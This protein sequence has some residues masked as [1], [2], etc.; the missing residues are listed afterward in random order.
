M[1]W[2]MWLRGRKRMERRIRMRCIARSTMRAIEAVICSRVWRTIV[3]HPGCRKTITSR[4]MVWINSIS[5]MDIILIVR[6]LRAIYI[7]AILVYTHHLLRISLEETGSVPL[8]KN[9]RKIC[10]MKRRPQRKSQRNW[11]AI[12]R[13]QTTGMAQATMQSAE[14]R[15]DS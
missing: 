2:S 9:R 13:L 3:I 6:I 4:S 14:A 11:T 7:L 8:M 5:T 12:Q 15:Q 10:L 1:I